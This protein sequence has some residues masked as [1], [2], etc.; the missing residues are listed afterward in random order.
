MRSFSHLRCRIG[1]EDP[2]VFR[3]RYLQFTEQALQDSYDNLELWLAFIQ[4]QVHGM[5]PATGAHSERDF[6]PRQAT[7]RQAG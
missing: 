7:L 2:G 4:G 5:L 3:K 6:L 1:R